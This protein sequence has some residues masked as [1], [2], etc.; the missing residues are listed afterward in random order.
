MPMIWPYK[1]LV[2]FISKTFNN[3]SQKVNKFTIYCGSYLKPQWINSIIIFL[4]LM[5]STKADLSNI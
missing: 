3:K 2:N 1:D 4:S 5:K